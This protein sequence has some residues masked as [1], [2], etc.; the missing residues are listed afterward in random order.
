[1]KTLALFSMLLCAQTA[2]DVKGTM[3]TASYQTDAS[4][5]A[6]YTALSSVNATVLKSGQFIFTNWVA[7]SGS[8][9]RWIKFY[10]LATNPATTDAP[11]LVIKT[12][13][14]LHITGQTSLPP[15]GVFIKN[16][17]A[18]RI[19]ANAAENDD[20]AVTAGDVILKYFYRAG[21]NE[22]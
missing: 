22:L 15:G 20:T 11:F 12:N 6:S 16:G 13:A 7:V 1:M 4:V 21:V 17:L 9:A 3:P 19:T 14:S 8:T 2:V 18:I 5:G 10:D